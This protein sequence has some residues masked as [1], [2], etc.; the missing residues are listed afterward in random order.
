MFI[1]NNDHEYLKTSE[2]YSTHDLGL[3]ASI[4]SNDF[5]LWSLD[6]SNPQKVRFIFKRK[7]GLDDIVEQYWKDELNVKA[8]RYFD[9]I[10]L[11]KNRIYSE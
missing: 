3:S 9:C 7:E 11:L 10:K 6:K 1:E 2:E 5:E 8:R 4:L